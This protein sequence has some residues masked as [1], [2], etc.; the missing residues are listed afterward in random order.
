MVLP[1]Q[2]A[3]KITIEFDGLVVEKLIQADR[4]SV[5]G[6]D[7]DQK[8]HD[9]ADARGAA[10]IIMDHQPNVAARRR[11]WTAKACQCRIAF[12]QK[13]WQQRNAHS[14]PDGP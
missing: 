13:C 6:N 4:P 12:P 7:G 8:I 2:E 9:G 14:G 1:W 3:E 10:Q 5:A 11:F